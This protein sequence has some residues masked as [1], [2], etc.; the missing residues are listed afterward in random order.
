MS[1]T[2]SFDTISVVIPNVEA[3]DS[4]ILLWMLASA[5]DA[6]AA[7]NSNGTNTLF[8]NNVWLNDHSG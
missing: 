8:A 6:A 5:A 4:N 1:F 3:L 2:S 7:V